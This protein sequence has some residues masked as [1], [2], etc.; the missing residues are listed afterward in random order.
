LI[1]EN[2]MWKTVWTLLTVLA[3]V[4]SILAGCGVTPEPTE[5][6]QPTVRPPTEEPA[7]DL[8]L[9]MTGAAMEVAWTA[10]DLMAM[11]T[12]S[13]DYTGKDGTVT[14]YTGVPM[15]SLLGLVG[16]GEA[17]NLVLVASDGY[18]AEIALADVQ[19]CDNCIVAFDPSG[20]LRAVLPDQSSK[21]QVEGLIELQVQ[22]DAA[23]ASA[24]PGVPEDA[25]LKIAGNVGAEIGW[26]EEDVRAMETM[27][28]ESTNKQGETA[29]YTG[30]SISKLLD[31]AEPAADAATVVFVAD[32][33]YTADVSLAEVQACAD[34]IVSFRNQG[35]F[36]IVM[37]GFGG[38]LQ[39]KGVVEIQ[40][41]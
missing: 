21:L 6:P 8:A 26:L 5:T 23:A 17:G 39:V 14:T 27:D 18:T 25:D 30:V 9:R 41:Q 11:D 2:R 33:G 29:T 13:V 38:G 37:P 19:S 1:E 22:G 20:G 35:G 24:A 28:A 16:A 34:C 36:G 7:G 3:L 40:V 10:D 15:A 31:M 32:D 4:V 12:L